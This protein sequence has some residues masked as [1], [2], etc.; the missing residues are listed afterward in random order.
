MFLNSTWTFLLR[1]GKII[2]IVYRAIFLLVSQNEEWDM[3]QTIHTYYHSINVETNF[4]NVLELFFLRH[5]KLF[6]EGLVLTFTG[7]NA[8]T[9][10][11]AYIAFTVIS[12]HKTRQ[13][14]SRKWIF[15]STA[16]LNKRR[17]L[18]LLGSE[19]LPIPFT[20]H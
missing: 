10:Q 16:L 3:H 4:K 1:L 19:M 5:K 17:C 20:K 8:M 11:T 13:N 14:Q 9:T 12:S 7:K 18:W 15:F 6:S 2:F